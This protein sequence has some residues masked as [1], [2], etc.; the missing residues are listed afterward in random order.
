M[1]SYRLSYIMTYLT[2]QSGFSVWSGGFHFAHSKLFEAMFTVLFR[3]LNVIKPLLIHKRRWFEASIWA[4][5]YSGLFYLLI[6]SVRKYNTIT[7]FSRREI[8]GYLICLNE[9]ERI[10]RKLYFY[11]LKFK[12]C[13]N[14]LARS[15][16]AYVRKVHAYIY[17]FFKR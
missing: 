2:N 8:S 1:W 9:K 16:L 17:N 10:F 4:H 15:T 14:Q 3:R 11:K 6:I 13:S 5:F 7:F 12:S